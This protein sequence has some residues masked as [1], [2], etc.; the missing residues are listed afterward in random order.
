[1]SAKSALL[2]IQ[3]AGRDKAIGDE[4]REIGYEADLDTLVKVGLRSGY[5]F[6]AEELLAAYKLDWNARWIFYCSGSFVC[7][8]HSRPA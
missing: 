1:M 3:H 4:I 2:F 6:T 7:I 8:K 5:C